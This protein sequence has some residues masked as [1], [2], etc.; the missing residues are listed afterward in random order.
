MKYSGILL[1]LFSHISTAVGAGK[2]HTEYV[3]SIGGYINALRAMQHHQSQLVW[4]RWLY[5]L[6]STYMW[7]NEWEVVV[8]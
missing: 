3:S 8:Q 5:V 1:P 4:F 2:A 6:F 7:V